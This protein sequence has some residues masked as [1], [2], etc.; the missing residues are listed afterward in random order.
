MGRDGSIACEE[1]KEGKR[2]K[3]EKRRGR[4]PNSGRGCEGA[5]GSKTDPGEK[6]IGTKRMK[7][8]RPEVDS[9]EK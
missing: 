8:S 2:E 1:S 4:R 7:N 6:E 9:G 5:G 3:K